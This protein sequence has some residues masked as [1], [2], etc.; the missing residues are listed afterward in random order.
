MGV[1][2][3]F[4]LTFEPSSLTAIA[5]RSSSGKPLP[6]SENS[7]FLY[8]DGFDLET[9]PR[10]GIYRAPAIPGKSIPLVH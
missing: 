3:I 4:E 9:L 8:L 1:T 6:A 7:S 2:L 10:P 5:I